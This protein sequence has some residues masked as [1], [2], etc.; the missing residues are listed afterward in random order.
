[1]TAVRSETREIGLGAP[2]AGTGNGIADAGVSRSTTGLKASIAASA[3]TGRPWSV[4]EN[5]SYPLV[6]SIERPG[7]LATI[8][9]KN[10]RDLVD[11]KSGE[12][13]KVKIKRGDKVKVTLAER[14]YLEGRMVAKL[15]E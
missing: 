14:D 8:D 15:L 10:W 4:D 5:D 7:I 3:I 9:A 1:M 12:T 11:P 6:G 13:V 2:S